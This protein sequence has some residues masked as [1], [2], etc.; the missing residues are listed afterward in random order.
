MLLYT[1]YINAPRRRPF[2]WKFS[3][4][5]TGFYSI[6][7]NRPAHFCM[8]LVVAVVMPQYSAVTQLQRPFCSHEPSQKHRVTS[9]ASSGK[10]G[11]AGFFCSALVCVCV[12]F[13]LPFCF[14]SL[15][16]A[17]LFNLFFSAYLLRG[18]TI[19][20]VNGNINKCVSRRADS[21]LWNIPTRSLLIVL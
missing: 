10:G 1:H 14:P 15:Y 4:F 19:A 5:M 16:R 8:G 21:V 12:C 13:F 20:V 7:Y 6:F 17:Q 9:L 18:F 3:W 2:A 11:P